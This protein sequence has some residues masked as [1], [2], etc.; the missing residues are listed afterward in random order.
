MF[1]ILLQLSKAMNLS[2]GMLVLEETEAW[3]GRMPLTVILRRKFRIG[4]ATSF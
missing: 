3:K 1:I 2:S 4:L